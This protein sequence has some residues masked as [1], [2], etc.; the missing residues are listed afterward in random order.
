[1]VF[2]FC[3]VGSTSKVD[4]TADIEKTGR[5]NFGAWMFCWLLFPL[6]NYFITWAR[7]IAQFNWAVCKR[8]FSTYEKDSIPDLPDGAWPWVLEKVSFSPK[9]NLRFRQK[10][11][12]Q[13]MGK[14]INVPFIPDDC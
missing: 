12:F 10:T 11:G 14:M 1:M 6:E 2:G 7:N 13:G 4:L 8:S 5:V 3:P 9:L